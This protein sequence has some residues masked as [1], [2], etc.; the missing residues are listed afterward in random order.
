MD[1]LIKGATIITQNA[2]RDTLQGDILIS[3]SR[4]AQVGKRISEKAEFKID[5]KG[6]LAMPGLINMHTHLAMSIFRGY[7]EGLP[8]ERWLK[9]KVWPMEAKET[10]ADAHVASQLALLEMLRSGTTAFNEMCML[11]AKEIAEAAN[12]AGVRGHVC[13]GIFDLLPGRT[14][15]GE[16][17][18]MER[19]AYPPEGLVSFGISPHAVYTCS[20]ELLAKANE[21]AMRRK[22]RIHTHAAE[23]R[24]EVFD[25]QKK[26]GK[27][28]LEYLGGLGLLRQGSIFAHC[29]WVTKK[30][31]SLAGKKRLSVVHCPASNLKLATGG[32]CPISEFDREGANVCIGTDSAASN[33]SLNMFESVKLAALLQKHM[34]WKADI[35]SAQKALDFATR[36]GAEAL[37]LDCGR[38]E[39]GALA[40]IILL[41]RGPNMVPMH[42]P[43]SNIVY[44]ANPSNVS[45]VIINGRLVM[46]NRKIKT[47]DEQAV[48]QK[49]EELAKE[50]EKR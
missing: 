17:K 28:V 9:E 38:I 7:G 34:Y 1:M 27:R 40:D 14:L 43:V 5:A 15:G 2:K 13:Q 25:L 35:L 22:L 37:G 18:T 3:G 31:I 21:F 39:Q 24:K 32:I 36:N 30:E 11:G 29:G 41:E 16:L 48:L 20:E 42:D 10:P 6:K 12:E 33:N 44:A 4:I 23:T 49:A 45:D 8:L 47:M 26:S 50:I 46:E 19:C